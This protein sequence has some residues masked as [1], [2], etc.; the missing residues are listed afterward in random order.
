MQA[1]FL[2]R[3][4]TLNKD[5]GYVHKVE[6]FEL[7]DDVIPSLQRL[8][9][10]ALFIVTNQSGVGRGHYTE[11]QMHAFNDYLAAE[12]N[13][14]GVVIRK[15]YACCHTPEQGCACRKPGT[16]FVE[17]AKKEFGVTLEKSWVIGDHPAD[18]LLAKNAG[19]R[20]VLVLTGHGAKHIEESRK[21][22][23]SYIAANLSQ[24]ATFILAD[25]DKKTIPRE[26]IGNVAQEERKKGKTIVTLN[27]T[28]DILHPGHEKIIREAK[29]QGDILIIAVNSDSSVRGN[30][31]PQRPFNNEQARARM[32][33]AFPE[34]DYVTV[35]PESHPIALLEDI[36][37]D[38]H[39]NGSEYGKDCI[40]AETV[41]KHGG[42]IH[43]VRL[44]EGHSTTT[45]VKG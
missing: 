20:S 8:K 29:A 27:G 24:A 36:R 1:I 22:Y 25:Q 33:A 39:V 2:D 28:F 31:G 15:V 34:V 3:D 32:I 11:Q 43:I 21:A 19:M 6:D 41:R 7:Y 45:L 16:Q 13:Q 44:L 38:V 30:K 17:Q 9:G 5:S 40:E 10:F 26:K 14:H 23:P 18:V 37:P 12:L 4:G 35:F 42:R